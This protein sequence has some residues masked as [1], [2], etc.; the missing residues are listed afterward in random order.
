[1]T[2][3]YTLNDGSPCRCGELAYQDGVVVGHYDCVGPPGDPGA[4]GCEDLS[5]EIEALRFA[6]EIIATH[7]ERLAAA[8]AR[9]DQLEA[10]EAE[11][12]RLGHG[13]DVITVFNAD[14]LP[15]FTSHVG[16]RSWDTRENRQR[17]H[18]FILRAEVA[19]RIL[20]QDTQPD[21]KVRAALR[22]F[23]G[24]ER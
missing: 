19:L 11:L 20:Q 14:G 10:A 23:E 9:L 8:N 7:N 2:C 15:S 5:E 18:E 1:M 13:V 17:A 6:R 24:V 12:K 3:R 21:E 16:D 4:T 22:A